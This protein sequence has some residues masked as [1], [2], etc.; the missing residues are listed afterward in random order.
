VQTVEALL[1][2]E[3]LKPFASALGPLGDEF[4]A[5]VAERTFVRPPK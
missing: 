5:L 1:F 2:S 4:T 3:V